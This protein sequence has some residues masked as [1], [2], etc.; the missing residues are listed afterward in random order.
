MTTYL[1][2]RIIHSIGVTV[3]V[4][5]LVFLAGRVVG[6]PVRIVVGLEA[7]EARV[8]RVRDALH[9][10]DPLPV[11]FGRFLAGAI[12]GDFGDSF[13]QKTPTLPLV[14]ERLPAT[15]YLAVVALLLI[16][17]PAITLGAIAALKP[18]SISDRVINV[19]SLGG[20]SIV[21]FW[22][23]LMLILVFGVHLG[24][25]R[26]SG[27]GGFRFIVLPALALAYKPLGRISQVTRSSMLDELR[28][29]YI[30]AAR[31]KGLSERR[32]VFTHALKNAAIPIIT[33]SG[34]ALA[35]LLNGAIVIETVFGWPGIGL[36]TIQALER[37]DLPLVE[38]T[39]FVVAVM[40]ILTNL[41]VD[42]AYTYLNPRI[43]FQ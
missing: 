9:L 40:V 32:V 6:D 21:E 30:K 2:R 19:V 14:L 24:W 29:P 28:K 41:F 36:L 20:V 7:E 26:T 8:Q 38:A 37:R 33:V 11:Q 23:A 34:D 1:L 42:I 43:R 10:N 13:W 3:V 17:P 4:L 16:V 35:S 39:V 22:L 15:L 12:R 5:A 25:F 31:A 27:Y 18:R